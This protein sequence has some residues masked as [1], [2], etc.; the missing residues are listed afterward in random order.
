MPLNV[1]YFSIRQPRVSPINAI[2]TLAPSSYGTFQ[3]LNCLNLEY[4]GTATTCLLYVTGNKI[5]TLCDEDR[6]HPDNIILSILGMTVQEIVSEL[7]SYNNYL[8]TILTSLPDD[9]AFLI[10]VD[11]FN[12]TSSD[13]TI[14]YNTQKE[15]LIDVNTQGDLGSSSVNTKTE[16]FT[17]DQQLSRWMIDEGKIF[18]ELDVSVD[19][20]GSAQVGDEGVFI[21]FAPTYNPDNNDLSKVISFSNVELARSLTVPIS[22]TIFQAAPI[23]IDGTLELKINQQI[24]EEG[25]DYLIDYGEK[26]EIIAINPQP[27]IFTSINN[28]LKIRWNSDPAQD[29]IFPSG[30]YNASDL[31]SIINNLSENFKADTFIND[32]GSSFLKIIGDRGTSY[33]QLRIEDGSANS[34][35]GFDDFKAKKGSGTGQIFFLKYVEEENIEITSV[36]DTFTLSAISANPFLGVSTNNFVLKQDNITLVQGEDY[37]VFLN[38]IVN[39]ITKIEQ[40]D[41]IQSVLKLD[42]ALFPPDYVI[43]EDGIPLVEGVDYV[44]NPQGGWITLENSAFPDRVYS[45][46][47]TNSIL[48]KVENE[49]ILGSPAEMLSDN[50]ANYSFNQFNNVFKVKINNLPE[51]QFTFIL[52]LLTS[53]QSIVSQ[54]NETAQGFKAFVKLNKILL[55]TI[56]SGPN[57]TITIGDGAANSILGF[58]NNKSSTGS[59]AQ[60]GERSLEVKNPPMNRIGF[61]APKNGDT[62]IIKNNDVTDRYKIN[63]VIKLINDYYQIENVSLETRANLIS[64]VSG[65]FTILEG[66]NDTFKFTIDSESETVVEFSQGSQI[67][68]SSIASKINSVR[69]QSARVIEFNGLQKIQLIGDTSVSIGNGSIN[70]TIGFDEGVED[71][72]TPDTFI[73]IIG[74]FKTTYI[75]PPVLTT[76]DPIIFH[77]EDSPKL[78][79]PQGSSYLRFIGDLT[80]KYLPNRFMR[81]NGLY[82]YRVI[83]SSFDGFTTEVSLH[84][85]LD[86]SIFEDTSIGFTKLS[87][88]EEGAINIKTKNLLFLDQPH[89]LRKNNN[90]LIQDNDYTINEGG[91]IE[92]TLGVEY[93][94]EFKIDYIARRYINSSNEIVAEYSYFDFI[95]IGSN[96]SYSLQIIN[97]DNFYINVLHGSTILSRTVDDLAQ[98]TQ[99]NLNSSSSGF[100][101]GEIPTIENDSSGS[102]TFNYTVGDLDDKIEMAKKI[103]EFYDDRLNNFEDEINAINGWIVGA[104]DGRVSTLD[105]ETSASQPPPTRLFPSPDSRPVEER[106]EPLRVPA[107]DGVNQNDSGS[108]GLGVESSYLLLD[109]VIEQNKLNDEKTK[110]N[111]L[112]TYSDLSASRVSAGTYSVIF[113]ETIEIYVEIDNGGLQQQNVSVTFNS[114]MIDVTDYVSAINSAVNSAFGATVNP[115][116]IFGPDIL[117]ASTASGTNAR[118][119]KIIVDAPSVNFGVN[120]EASVRSRH[121]L[122]T[123]GATYSIPVPGSISV[124]NDII[125]H[126]NI[127]SI[128]DTRHNDQLTAILGQLIEWLPP[129]DAAFD[130]AKNEKLKVN[131]AL[132]DSTFATS[133]SNT[134]N[135]IKF[136]N[137][138]NSIDNTAVIDGRISEIDA[139]ISIINS[140]ISDLNNRLSQISNTISN[141]GL[142]DTRYSWVILLADKSSGYYAS[143]DREIL[144]EQKKQR[145]AANN[146][147]AVNNLNNI[148]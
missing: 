74:R 142:Y 92:L 105:I 31:A 135:N 25:K 7:N 99:S 87:I 1:G 45:A 51:Q 34:V 33:H 136:S 148:F 48:G 113:D 73:K 4:T 38:G 121:S 64:S 72:N 56:E 129:Y 14:L 86:T 114:L 125:S 15:Y 41:L 52:N 42:D 65:P 32:S 39:L 26:P 58:V 119:I 90:V 111:T 109:L 29:F 43:Y 138:F 53:A 22:S 37:L 115:A 77:E 11:G 59:G 12:L 134:F 88:Y 20:S 100:P 85:K 131:Q 102:S 80:K 124:N 18:D 21:Q 110:L 23:L 116:S 143:K 103:F 17:Y 19:L 106:T 89:T 118:S 57:K 62:I 2:S 107:L 75:S 61:T 28:T 97:P 78:Q 96:I 127:R 5:L 67:S 79:I 69:P 81:I 40:E 140:R 108:S 132:L 82:Y 6:N 50:S 76:I 36:T 133:T 123:A 63:T 137:P 44:I 130:L 101:T 139:R 147:Q 95:R 47:Y 146:A 117:L 112:K 55:K 66:T 35:F 68:V 54:I 27:Y 145:E 10:G 71:T 30:S 84:N 104:E 83:S 126:N 70:R 49:I 8:A 93:G 3:T 144:L 122:Y 94:D 128:I 91:D 16:A 141:E 13:H 98:K 46:S 60:G 24:V 120:S 9:L